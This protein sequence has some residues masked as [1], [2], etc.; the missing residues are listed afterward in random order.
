L[1]GNLIGDNQEALKIYWNTYGKI[2]KINDIFDNTKIRFAYSPGGNRIVKDMFDTAQYYFRDAQG[3]IMAIY[4]RYITNGEELVRPEP[5]EI[6]KA[7]F[8][9]FLYNNID[10]AT[11]FNNI[12]RVSLKDST[13]FE[14]IRDAFINNGGDFLSV[15]LLWLDNIGDEEALGMLIA[16]LLRDED[17]DLP[18]DR[19][20]ADAYWHISEFDLYGSSRLGTI[21]PDS[22][23]KQL[24]YQAIY[25][26]LNRQYMDYNEMSIT[27]NYDTNTYDTLSLLYERGEKFF[28]LCN[29]L[30]NVMVTVSD[31][32]LPKDTL[33]NNTADH[34]RADV[35]SAGDYYAF[36]MQMPGRNY[37]LYEYRFGFN[38][39]EKDNQIYGSGNSYTAEFWQYDARLGRRWNVDPILK[40]WESPFNCFS[41]NPIYLKDP[42]GLTGEVTKTE[43]GYSDNRYP[44]N[45]SPLNVPGNVLIIRANIYLY[46]DANSNMAESMETTMNNQLNNVESISTPNGEINLPN[47]SS[48]EIDGERYTVI[49]DVNVEYKNVTREQVE[50]NQDHKNN[51]IR[52]GND[53]PILNFSSSF[54]AAKDNSSRG[55]S[56]GFFQMPIG[57]FTGTHEFLESLGG[58]IHSDMPNPNSGPDYSNATE[59]PYRVPTNYQKVP[60]NPIRR[61]GEEDLNTFIP[62]IKWISDTKGT[63]G[64]IS[65]YYFK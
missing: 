60:S 36:G 16:S 26:P 58:P 2:R 31:R 57:K 10:T 35:L 1:I 19:V 12:L 61:L 4:S 33:G 34:F 7:S 64:D 13:N 63:I 17:I 23:I 49:F 25:N 37:S 30:G 24:S 54:I 21:H 40:V 20:P 50:S 38:G 39:Q 29:H 9:E 32:K 27:Y 6:M 11:F 5:D 51:Y 15:T 43:N 65:H 56:T 48:I 18:G 59:I 28:E 52:V 41:N 22:C 14:M 45:Q 47:Y 42:T 8:V 62:L 46:G 55:G 44:I 53:N 3:N